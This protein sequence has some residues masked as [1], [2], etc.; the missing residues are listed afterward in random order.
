MVNFWFVC[1]MMWE[2]CYHHTLIYVDIIS[3]LSL[4]SLYKLDRFITMSHREH[5]ISLVVNQYAN[6]NDASVVIY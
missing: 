6:K 3:C 5:N 1:E 2:H 4:A